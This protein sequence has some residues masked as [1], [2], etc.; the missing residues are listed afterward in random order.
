M[1]A[2]L[3]PVLE[4]PAIGKIG[5]NIKYD[6]HIFIG[7]GIQ[8]KGIAQDTMLQSYVL[9]STATRHNMDALAKY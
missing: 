8:L 9:N 4:N 6:A 5:Q 7:E 1:L 2:A 3:K